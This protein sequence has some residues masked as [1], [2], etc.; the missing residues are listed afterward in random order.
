MSNIKLLHPQEIE[1]MFIL[2]TIRKYLAIEMKELGYSQKEIASKL[3]ITASAISQYLKEKRASRF[4]LPNEVQ[5]KIKEAANKIESKETLISEVQKIMVSMFE[6][7][8]ICKI[9]EEVADI[10]TNCNICFN[11]VK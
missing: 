4:T 6:N 7:R 1:A 2:P 5:K 3:F 9:H 10:P 11:E 8:S